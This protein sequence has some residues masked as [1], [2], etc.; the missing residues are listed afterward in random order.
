MIVNDNDQKVAHAV[1]TSRGQLLRP[2]VLTPVQDHACNLR[3][4]PMHITL[5]E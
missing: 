3:S 4:K 2:T 1:S 5:M